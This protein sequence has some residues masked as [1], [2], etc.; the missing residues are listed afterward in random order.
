MEFDF[1]ILEET[2][3]T[4]SEALKLAKSTDRPT[5]VVAKKTDKWTGSYWI[6][7]G[8]TQAEISLAQY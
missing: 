6:E 2:E 1:V 4:N 3:S 5:F 8:Q 7:V